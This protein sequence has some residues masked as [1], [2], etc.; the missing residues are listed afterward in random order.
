MWD[1]IYYRNITIRNCNFYNNYASDGSSIYYRDTENF[2][3]KYI[4]QNS[5]FIGDHVSSDG[6]GVVSAYNTKTINL[7]NVTIKDTFYEKDGK[8]DFG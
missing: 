3:G 1:T 8:I 6:G 5:Q 2:P 4:I 7:Y